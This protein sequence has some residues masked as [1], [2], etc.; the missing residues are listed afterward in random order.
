MKLISYAN[1]DLLDAK[2][3]ERKDAA[4]EKLGIDK[5]FEFTK[6]Y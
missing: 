1:F 6:L 4:L 2:I 3:A 5:D